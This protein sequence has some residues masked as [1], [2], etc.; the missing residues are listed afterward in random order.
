M[1]KILGIDL[2]TTNSVAAYLEGKNPEVVLGL[3]GNRLLPSVVAFTAGG[4][5]LVGNPA[6]GQMIT[7]PLGTVFSVKRLMGRR[8]SEMEPYLADFPYPLQ[9]HGDDQLRIQ[10]GENLFSP[11]E[12]SAMI[13]SRL[14]EAAEAHLHEP[15]EGA[16]I[17]V[18]AYFNDSQRQATRDAGTIAGLNVLRIINEPTAAS[19]AYSIDLKRQA[20]LAVYDFGGGTI[21]ISIL[22]VQDGVIK[23]LATL[24]DTTLG[25]SNFD[26]MLADKL[27]RE[28]REEFHL[29]L[30][31]DKAA[32]QRIREA[33]EVAKIELSSVEECEINLPFIAEGEAGPLHLV[34]FLRRTELENL[35]EKQVEGTMAL[36]E[37][38][39]REAELKVGAIDEV[40]L[41]GG[42]TRIPLVQGRVRDFFHRDPNRRVNPD[43]IVA[44]GAALQGGIV[45]GASRD[46]LLLDVT[47]LSLGVRTFGGAFTRIIK[48]NTTIPVSRSMVFST[49]E[50]DQTEVDIHIYQGEREIAEENKFLG[51]FTLLDIPVAPRGVPRIEVSFNIDI[52]G[53][54]IVSAADLTSHHQKQIVV[55]QT[56]LLLEEE[57][58]R[59]RKEAEEF[60]ESDQARRRQIEWKN[61]V[62]LRV[63]T[64]R[65]VAGHL[66]PDT[67]LLKA[68]EE[69]LA[70]AQA[71]VEGEDG[72]A[73]EP[74]DAEL[75]A[76]EGKIRLL[77]PGGGEEADLAV[78]PPPP[79][80]SPDEGP[81]HDT[82]PFKLEDLGL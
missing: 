17:T 25:G 82:R 6:K 22:E 27:I 56:G 68:A 23:V 71:A 50:D 2:G 74:I 80:S 53:I 24:G 61:R 36:C 21:D 63:H 31:R 10:V 58:A 54:L 14:R 41:V 59:M 33:A 66:D 60:Y 45:S 16:I 1:G 55:S 11:E 20:K 4:E 76:M 38:A 46:I 73:L 37:R 44:M 79:S 15:V 29:D 64:L 19:L 26:I 40:L 77:L 13:L 65:T 75:A 48:A 72:P 51:K 9:C 57:I 49:A 62:Y 35:I 28:F 69:L 47:P 70:R 67:P 78:T 52:N 8:Y 30:G 81:L 32:M 12:I 39:L 18:P 34:R 7:N 43:E 3:E 42:S 5:R